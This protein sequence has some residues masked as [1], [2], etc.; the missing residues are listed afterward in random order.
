MLAQN[1]IYK[2]YNKEGA[3]NN[4]DLFLGQAMVVTKMFPL[5]EMP[6]SFIGH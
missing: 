1:G 2:K 4:H 6:I 5:N 3:M